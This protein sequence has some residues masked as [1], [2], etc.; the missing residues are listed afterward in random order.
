[1]SLIIS[2]L[3]SNGMIKNLCNNLDLFTYSQNIV[4]F[5]YIL[6]IVAAIGS[7]TVLMVEKHMGK[8]NVAEQLRDA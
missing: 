7:F 8:K 1:M 5:A 6:F 3:L 4:V 2:V